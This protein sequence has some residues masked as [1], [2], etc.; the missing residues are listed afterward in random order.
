MLLIYRVQGV[1]NRVGTEAV[2]NPRHGYTLRL[3]P[4]GDL[5]RSLKVHWL[6]VNVINDKEEKKDLCNL[7][8][9]YES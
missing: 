3:N 1:T 2:D 4:I 5:Q 8:V 9:V 7:I 6:C